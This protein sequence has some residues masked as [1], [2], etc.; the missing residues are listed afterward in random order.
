M[1]MAASRA[2]R[3]F[4]L[5]YL[6]VGALLCVIAIV[7][8]P[9]VYRGMLQGRFDLE[10]GES[11]IFVT[12]AAETDPAWRWRYPSNHT[13]QQATLTILD[14]TERTAQLDLARGTWTS[15]SRDGQL[16]ADGLAR[17]LDPDQGVATTR[18]VLPAEGQSL[19]HSLRQMHT[20]RFLRPRH[21]PYSSAGPGVSFT[22]FTF[23]QNCGGH[24]V[25][26]WLLAWPVCLALLWRRSAERGR[27]PAQVFVMT[28]AVVVTL[29]LVFIGVDALAPAGG[30]SETMEL[31]LGLVNLPA[32]FVMSGRS[33]QTW[34]G[35]AFAAVSWSVLLSAATTFIRPVQRHAACPDGP[36]SDQPSSSE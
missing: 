9:G 11:L 8:R 20:G 12:L 2:R 31:L 14:D 16:D 10:I 19:L 33:F 1:T 27:V 3:C 4:A 21:I 30:V 28:G 29:D 34:M 15:G 35:L 36:V 6:V 23:G 32:V 5:C 26:A 25:L 22:H 18:P 17:L 7:P 24:A 13:Y